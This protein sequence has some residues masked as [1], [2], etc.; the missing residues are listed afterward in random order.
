MMTC[1]ANETD[2]VPQFFVCFCKLQEQICFNLWEMLTGSGLCWKSVSAV[3][4][5]RLLVRNFDVQFVGG[6]GKFKALSISY[7]NPW[8]TPAVSELL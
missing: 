7:F 6:V 3:R 8:E 4:G 1:A 2:T 5:K